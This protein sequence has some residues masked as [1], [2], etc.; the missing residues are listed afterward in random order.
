MAASPAAGR[1]KIDA[2]NKL[3][4]STKLVSQPGQAGH[5]AS[6]KKM[7]TTEGYQGLDSATGPSPR[8]TVP[9]DEAELMDRMANICQQ[10]LEELQPVLKQIT[11]VCISPFR[12]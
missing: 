4:T 5:L 11:Q 1:H 10:T 7:K 2:P 9:R 8:A 6:Q 12:F 3:A